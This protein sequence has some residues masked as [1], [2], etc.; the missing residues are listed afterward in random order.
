M[1][2]YDL[3]SRCLKGN[4]ALN[5]KPMQIISISVM[6]FAML[7]SACTAPTPALT[8]PPQP[9]APPTTESPTLAPSPTE[10]PSPT[11]SPM[12]SPTVAQ[13]ATSLPKTGGSTSLDPC[14]LLD[15]S[16]AK[17]LTGVSFGAGVE[18]TLDG[19]AK[20]CTYG[21]NTTNVLMV[22]VGQAKDVAT[23]QAYQASFL[24]DIKSGLAQFGDVP[25]QVTQIPDFGS[26][27]VSATLGQNAI[28]VTGSAFGFR[29]NTI[30][31][32]FSD[33]VLGA[34]APTPAAMR[35]EAAFVLG[36]LP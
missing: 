5:K 8:N 33:L 19:G 25:F 22:E 13:A 15:S 6:V 17:N 30:F 29:K 1:Y 10:L 2:C 34:P 27:A 28:N 32:G 31:F 20:M 18:S 36:E 11:A 7:L 3:E 35:A 26:G 21:A 16:E 4:T 24:N 14:E 12:P 9:T 23:A